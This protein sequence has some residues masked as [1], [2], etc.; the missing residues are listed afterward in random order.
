LQKSKNTTVD[1]NNCS[2]MEEGISQSNH[3][4]TGSP[5]GQVDIARFVAEVEQ[6]NSMTEPAAL[7]LYAWDDLRRFV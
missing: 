6:F 2:A 3:D 7:L 5:A 4:S 1:I